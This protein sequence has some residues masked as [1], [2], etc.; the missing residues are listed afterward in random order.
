MDDMKLTPKERAILAGVLRDREYLA[1]LDWT[2]GGVTRP[3]LG[4][5]RIRIADAREGYVPMNLAG[6][7]S[8]GGRSPTPSE[9]V[10]YHRAYK[11]LAERGLLRRVSLYGDGSRTSHLQLTDRGEA[12]A[13]NLCAMEARR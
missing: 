12:V 9:A 1:G 11:R 6:W 8:G 13:R 3:Q 10:M 2:P 7:I 5:Y 4:A